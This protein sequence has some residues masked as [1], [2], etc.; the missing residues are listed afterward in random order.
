MLEEGEVGAGDS[1]QPVKIDSNGMTIFEINQLMYFDK[2]NYRRIR[3]AIQIKELS[4]GW[5]NTFE[6]RLSKE[7]ITTGAKEAYRTFLVSKKVPES[8]TI[9]SFYLE[10]EDR[11]PL[12]PF[13]NRSIP[14][15]KVGYTGAIPTDL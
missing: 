3:D 4:P 13:F 7:K 1:I 9:T 5:K 15:N 8:E 14:S 12:D 2:D 11:K 6:D 10:P